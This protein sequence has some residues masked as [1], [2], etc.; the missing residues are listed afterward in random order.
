VIDDVLS[1]AYEPALRVA[2]PVRINFHSRTLAGL[3]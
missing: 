1:D 2:E 3:A